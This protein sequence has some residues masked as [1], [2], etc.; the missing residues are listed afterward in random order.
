MRKNLLIGLILFS[1]TGCGVT[2]TV[3]T[4]GSITAKGC[5]TFVKK[6]TTISCIRKPIISFSFINDLVKLLAG[7]VGGVK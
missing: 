2:V 1:L 5:D 4:D 7:T 3:K 6:D